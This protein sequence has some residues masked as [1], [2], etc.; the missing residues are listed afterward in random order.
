M[1]KVLVMS[2][3][4]WLRDN[5]GDLGWRRMGYISLCEIA[6]GIATPAVNSNMMR[7][8]ARP[9]Q[10]QTKCLAFGDGQLPW[11]LAS[12]GCCCLGPLK[13]FY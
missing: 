7:F 3:V 4:D 1:L 6:L 11:E 12:S 5:E 10:T 8:F 9:W 13:A 2:V